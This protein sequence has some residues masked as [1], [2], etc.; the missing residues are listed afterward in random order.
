MSE[1]TSLQFSS[2]VGADIAISTT[3]GKLFGI[4]IN[5]GAGNSYVEIFDALSSAAG[6]IGQVNAIANDSRYAEFEGARFSTGLTLKVTGAGASI[7]VEFKE[8]S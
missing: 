4:T 8:N 6:K 1:H 3:R 5:A 2:T 7:M